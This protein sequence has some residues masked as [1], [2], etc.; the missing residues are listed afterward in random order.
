MGGRGPETMFSQQLWRRPL[1]P[2]PTPRL[3]LEGTDSRLGRTS[4]PAHRPTQQDPPPPPRRAIAA[5]TMRQTSTT[6][7]A[8]LARRSRYQQLHDNPCHLFWVMRRAL[9]SA[10]V[11]G[12]E[13]EMWNRS[14]ATRY[15]RSV[16]DRLACRQGTGDELPEQYHQP[17]KHGDPD[18]EIGC[19]S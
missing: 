1:G 15:L 5:V 12:R 19:D 4:G 13:I 16:R 17:S 14:P 6:L 10:F 8:V 7:P 9:R 18:I 3:G 2:G 11:W